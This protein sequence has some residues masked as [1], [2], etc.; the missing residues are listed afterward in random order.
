MNNRVDFK[1]LFLATITQDTFL[2]TDAGFLSCNLI[3]QT[4]LALHFGLLQHEGLI[5]FKGQLLP[6]SSLHS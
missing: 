3:A 6:T 5:C 4:H 1:V 2:N